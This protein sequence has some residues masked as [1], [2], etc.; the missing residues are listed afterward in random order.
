MIISSNLLRALSLSSF[1]YGS[2]CFHLRINIALFNMEI[3]DIM[4]TISIL[5]NEIHVSSTYITKF[6]SVYQKISSIFRNMVRQPGHKLILCPYFI[7]FRTF[8]SGLT[9]V[10]VTGS[11]PAPPRTDKHTSSRIIY[12][13]TQWVEPGGNN[14]RPSLL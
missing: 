11:I 12:T 9:K 14:P 2:E 10:E 6:Y 5:Y 1:P 7:Y 4:L 3:F 13:V 8:I